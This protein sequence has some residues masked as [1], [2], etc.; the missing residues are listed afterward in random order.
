MIGQAGTTGAGAPVPQVMILGL[1]PLLAKGTTLISGAC[2]GAT[3]ALALCGSAC[4]LLACRRLVPPSASVIFLLFLTAAWVSVIDL[5]LQTW[6]YPLRQE[7]GIYVPLI[8][9]NCL[10]L[11]TLE[12]R[13]LGEG[14]RAALARVFLVGGGVVLSVAAAGAIRELAATGTLLGDAGLLG[15]IPAGSGAGAGLAVMHAPAGAFLTLALLAALLQRFARSGA[16][17]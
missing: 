15:F 10:V 12:E 6:L 1:C 7:L 11:S 14:T 16:A 9:A 5:G 3:A 17:D 4:C 8:A 13:M 2:L